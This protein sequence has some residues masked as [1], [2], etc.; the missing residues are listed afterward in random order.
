MAKGTAGILTFARGLNPTDPYNLT[1]PAAY[2]QNVNMTLAGLISTSAHPERAAKTMLDDFMKDPSE[3]TG[4]LLPNLLGDGAGLEA[5]FGRAAL[6]EGVES[7]SRRGA[8]VG[9]RCGRGCGGGG[10]EGGY[11]TS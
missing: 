11:G 4:R 6:K 8:A 2:V 5:A 7:G 1:H 10:P 9:E 3:G